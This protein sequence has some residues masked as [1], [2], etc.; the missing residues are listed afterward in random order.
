MDTVLMVIGLLVLVAGI[1][2]F[3]LVKSGIASIS[4][5]NTTTGKQKKWGG[6]K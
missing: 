3:A 6:E 5:N 2:L 1:I 4:I